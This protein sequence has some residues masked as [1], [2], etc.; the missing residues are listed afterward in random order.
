MEEDGGW[1]VDSAQNSSVG[2]NRIYRQ[3][4]NVAPKGHR[5][6]LFQ[7]AGILSSTASDREVLVSVICGER[8][9]EGPNWGSGKPSS[10]PELI[11]RWQL[12]ELAS[13]LMVPGAGVTSVDAPHNLIFSPFPSSHLL[14][15]LPL[16]TRQ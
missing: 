1:R 5:V 2:A 3:L 6:I 16:S 10:R 4:V 13:A 15:F 14:L 12:A 9:A 7:L 8:E 11:S